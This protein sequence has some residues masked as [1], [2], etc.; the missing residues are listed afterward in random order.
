MGKL[1]PLDLLELSSSQWTSRNKKK[2]GALDRLVVRR[3]ELPGRWQRQRLRRLDPSRISPG[4]RQA[5]RQPRCGRETRRPETSSHGYEVSSSVPVT[6]VSRVAHGWVAAV[7]GGMAGGAGS[8]GVGGKG[9]RVS[10]GRPRATPP[11]L[12]QRRASGQSRA[13]RIRAQGLLLMKN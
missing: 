3:H 8:S 5:R 7:R 6:L 13:E 12:A 2:S 11:R 1:F 4:R 10:Q 9:P